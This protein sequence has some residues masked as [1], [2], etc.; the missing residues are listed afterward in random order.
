MT[1]VIDNLRKLLANTYALVLKTQN[2]HWH[3]T[4]PHFRTYHLMFE[5][6]YKQLFV[7]TDLLAERI[8]ALGEKAPASFE[9]FIKLSE[10]KA[11]DSSTGVTH[12]IQDLVHDYQKINHMIKAILALA[13]KDNDDATAAV[14]SDLLVQYE[15]THWILQASL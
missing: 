14:L 10:L 1:T 6:Q 5:E 4:G 9:E 15:K 11:G 8:R 13:N 7:N 3:V 2:Y 12:M